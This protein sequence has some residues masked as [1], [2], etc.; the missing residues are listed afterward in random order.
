MNKYWFAALGVL[1][2]S[3]LAQAAVTVD[4]NGDR[5]QYSEN[6]RLVEVLQPYALQQQWYWPAATLF[7]TDTQHAEQLRRQLLRLATEL[8]QQSDDAPLRDSLALLQAQVNKWQLADRVNIALDYDAATVKPTLNRRFDS[9]SYRLQLTR[10]PVSV[11]VSG[12]VKRA[13][14]APHIGAGPVAAYVVNVQMLSGADQSQLAVV[15]PDGRIVKAGISYWNDSHVE[16][17]PGA[18]LLVLFA[19]PLLDNRFATLNALLQQLAVHRILP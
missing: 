6:P 14:S 13:F 1:L 9:G 17:M 2:C 10:R 12:A 19:E 7:R 4:V 18:Q 8:A 16:A 5:R 3:T 11:H 15:Q